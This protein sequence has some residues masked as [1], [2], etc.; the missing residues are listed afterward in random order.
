MSERV[1][2]TE[3]VRL[4]KTGLSYAKIGKVF[5]ISGVTA[6]RIYQASER[7]SEE[8]TSQIIGLLPPGSA[9][10]RLVNFWKNN[11]S[12]RIDHF[13]AIGL[14]AMRK[15]AMGWPNC[16]KLSV[17]TLIEALIK[18][19]EMNGILLVPETIVTPGITHQEASFARI[20]RSKGWTC[21]PPAPYR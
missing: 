9:T 19:A 3:I 16:G 8:S 21:T 13:L 7:K 17:D 2:N 14:D 5:S 15:E 20:L 12:P 18:Y 4:R 1:R 11:G 10:T 6:A